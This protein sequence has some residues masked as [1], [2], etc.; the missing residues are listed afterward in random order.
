LDLVEL[1]LK[2]GAN[3]ECARH[4]QMHRFD[5]SGLPVRHTNCN[6]TLKA[7]AKFQ[8]KWKN[9]N[10]AID[11]AKAAAIKKFEFNC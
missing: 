8:M 1:L 3:V 11:A 2:A 9:G 7:G 10:S 4:L 6:P 5:G